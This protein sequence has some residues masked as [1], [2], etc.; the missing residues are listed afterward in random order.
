VKYKINRDLF[1][2]PRCSL[3]IPEHSSPTRS[4]SSKAQRYDF[5]A[6]HPRIR[7]DIIPPGLRCGS[8]GG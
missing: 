4:L 3:S 8:L 7:R 6:K 5:S 1:L 2:F